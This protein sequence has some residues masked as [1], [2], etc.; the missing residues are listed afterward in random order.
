VCIS[1][2]FLDEPN[3]GNDVP[4]DMQAP[5]YDHHKMVTKVKA[6]EEYWIGC[7]EYKTYR[8]LNISYTN[9]FEGFLKHVDATSYL[10]LDEGGCCTATNIKHFFQNVVGKKTNCLC[11]SLIKYRQAI[12]KFATTLEDRGRDFNCKDFVG[13]VRALNQVSDNNKKQKLANP[14]DHHKKNPTRVISELDKIKIMESALSCLYESVFHSFFVGWNVL[15]RIWVRSK[16]LINIYWKGV[17][18][19]HPSYLPYPNFPENNPNFFGVTFFL[20]V[21]KQRSRLTV[22]GS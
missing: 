11:S 14:E 10:V 13:V 8:R 1:N 12:N 18:V 7:N 16:S 19:M 2:Q 3:A 15:C 9:K 21:S 5:R 22:V 6:K 20:T 17:G 4:A